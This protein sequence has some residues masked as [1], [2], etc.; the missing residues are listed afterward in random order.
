MSPRE[1][2]IRIVYQELINIIG[3]S[4]G[5]SPQTTG[6]IMMIGLQGS[7]KNYHNIKTCTLLPEE[8]TENPVWFCADTFRARCIP[9]AEDSLY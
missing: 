4:T 9:A 5:H 6:T 7:G 1:H 2:V 3:K 8:R